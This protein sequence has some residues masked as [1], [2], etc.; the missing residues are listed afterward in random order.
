MGPIVIM[1]AGAIRPS[2]IPLFFMAIGA[3][4][5]SMGFIQLQAGHGVPEILRIPAAVANGALGPELGDSLA[6]GMAAPAFDGG[7]IP[8]ERP[9][10]RSMLKSRSFL[11][12]VTTVAA[13]PGVTSRTDGMNLLL[14]LGRPNR[15]LNIMAVIA[16][17]LGVA[18]DAT[19][20]E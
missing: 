6:G 7:M 4:R 15:F 16:A 2:V 14:R 20:V 13:V 8:V 10:G 9:A 3:I 5:L 11:G 1:T 17:L 19:E 18:I 12:V